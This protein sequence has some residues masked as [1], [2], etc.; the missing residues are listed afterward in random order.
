MLIKFIK[1]KIYLSQ[2]KQMYI[3]NQ[4]IF[5][6]FHKNKFQKLGT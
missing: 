5:F 3:K 6:Y 1:F 2:N 4:K